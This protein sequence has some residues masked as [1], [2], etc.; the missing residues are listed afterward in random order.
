M[1]VS[2]IMRRIVHTV[3]ANDTL[4]TASKHMASEKVG[5]L[6]V[7][8]VA[9]VEESRMR[10]DVIANL[11]FLPVVEEDVLVGVITTR[12]IVVRSVAAGRDPEKTPVSAI[13]TQDFA[14]CQEDDAIEDAL[15]EMER[16]KVR[17]LFALNS[18]KQVVG[19]VSRHDIWAAR[20]GVTDP[21]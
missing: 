14:C 12:D 17:R 15:A 10:A 9:L 2:D 19:I 13:M 8:E 20:N 3:R 18:E 6:P 21:D 16:Q 1:K 4:A 5:L 11:G 7:V